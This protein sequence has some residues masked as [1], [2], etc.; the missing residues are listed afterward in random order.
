MPAIKRAKNNPVLS[1]DSNHPWEA[2]AVFNWCPVKVGERIHYL[3]RAMSEPE[4]MDQTY[5]KLSVIG[6]ASSKGY[7]TLEDRRIFISPEFEWEKYG[8]E[9]PRVTKLGQKYYTFYTALSNYPFSAEGIKIAVAISDDFKKVKEKHLV[10]P[11]NAK[12]MALFSEKINGKMCALLTVNTDAPPS[13][14]AFVEFEKETDLWSKDFWDKWYQNLEIHA[15]QLK[16]KK[17]DHIEFGAPPLLTE[18]GWLLIYSY[19]QNYFEGQRVFGVEAALLDLNNPRK[20]IGQTTWP[21]LVPEAPYEKYGSVP[22]IVFPTGAL[23]D[24]K[25]LKIFYGAADTY[26][27]LASVNLDKFLESMLVPGWRKNV[28]RFENNPILSPRLGKDWEEK[29]VFNPA[30]I[31]LEGKT[32]ILYRAFSKENVSTIG[33]AVTQDGFTIDERSNEPI[34][35]PRE[36]F[37]KKEGGGGGGC[38]DPRIIKIE[39]KLYLTYTAFDG[40]KPRIASTSIKVADFLAKKWQWTKPKLITPYEVEDKDCVIFPEKI[41]GK[42]LIIHRI[43]NS[44]CGDFVSSLDFDKEIIDQCIEM[45]A[46]RPGMWD[47]KKV[48][49]ACPPIKTDKG[50][51]LLYHGVS[52]KMV[53]RVGAVLLGKENPTEIIAR[54]INPILEPSEKYEKVGIVPNVVFPCGSVLKGDTLFIYYGAA[55]FTVGVATVS[56]KKILELLK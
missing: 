36:S 48:G 55:D 37:E 50:W 11:F 56:L 14:I 30:A 46:P 15:L 34:Y 5:I 13:Q 49:A 44:I 35:L 42:Y 53:Y 7:Q 19:I 3:Y 45:I 25:E 27:A 17:E 41:D 39:D 10:T 54:G 1:A 2:E 18:K 24:G 47:S 26:G 51:L 22:N 21:V 28:K 23:I 43:E 33:Y 31:Y 32:H 8:C 16:R 6:H 38:E 9:D 4:L 20:I 52:E 29:G 12:G 40:V